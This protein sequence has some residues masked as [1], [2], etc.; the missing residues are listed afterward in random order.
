MA[1]KA[2]VH[3]FERLA[4][5]AWPGH[6][7]LCSADFA[8]GLPNLPPA[9][10]LSNVRD[11]GMNTTSIFKHTMVTGLENMTDHVTRPEAHNRVLDYWGTICGGRTL[12]GDSLPTT[13]PRK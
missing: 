6:L 11:T 1:A 7:S 4:N 13:Q 10:S 12:W 3:V 5:S 8:K 2:L 9:K